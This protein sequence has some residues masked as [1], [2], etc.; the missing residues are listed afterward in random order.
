MSVKESYNGEDRRDSRTER[1]D[2]SARLFGGVVTIIIFLLLQA[3]GAIGWM[4]SQTTRMDY[5]GKELADLKNKLESSLGNSY[6]SSQASG[7]QDYVDKRIDNLQSVMVTMQ[8]SYEDLT[9]KVYIFQDVYK[10]KLDK[11]K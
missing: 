11:L 8:N 3:G 7:R 2:G 6:T 5:M 4:A 9:R 10:I 1:T